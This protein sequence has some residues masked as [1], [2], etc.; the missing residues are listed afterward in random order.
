MS[1]IVFKIVSNG[2][3]NCIQMCQYEGNFVHECLELSNVWFEYINRVWGMFGIM[4][5]NL[6]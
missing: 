3:K 4:Q 5:K 1:S 6:D 2:S